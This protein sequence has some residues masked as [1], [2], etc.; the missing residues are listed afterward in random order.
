FEPL[1]FAWAEKNVVKVGQTA[2]IY[3]MLNA[4][5]NCH[6]QAY[7]YK[8]DGKTT[9]VYERFNVAPGEV[10][11]FTDSPK[12]EGG[13]TY[14]IE[15]YDGVST[16]KAS[17][18]IAVKAEEPPPPGK[19]KKYYN[20]T[21]IVENSTGLPIKGAEVY[22]NDAY[23]G[24]TLENGTLSVKNIEEGTYSLRVTA[25][26]YKEYSKV[27]TI[28]SNLV[29]VTLEV[30][31]PNVEVKV[32]PSE[33]WIMAGEPF[34]IK[35]QIQT[36]GPPILIETLEYYTTKGVNIINRS[37]IENQVLQNGDVI[38]VYEGS[39]EI[40]GS[41]EITFTLRYQLINGERRE[42]SKTVNVHCTGFSASYKRYIELEI[43]VP[44]GNGTLRVYYPEVDMNVVNSMSKYLRSESQNLLN[45]MFNGYET[46]KD[47]VG[48]E[49]ETPY[50][51][52][53][54]HVNISANKVKIGN[55]F[56]SSETTVFRIILKL[57]EGYTLTRY[58][59][60]FS[61]Y[62]ENGYLTAIAEFSATTEGFT[63]IFDK[64]EKPTGVGKEGGLSRLLPLI[65]VLAAIIIGLM[66][67]LKS[68]PKYYRPSRRFR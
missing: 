53:Y 59:Q 46:I 16:S 45:S 44:D 58:P 10:A 55:V 62:R 25:N 50:Y 48:L 15:A 7:V 36:S 52:L 20:V 17:L 1:I 42:I 19:E 65:G 18:Q 61:I 32:N 22:L 49:G 11:T 5:F 21:F 14:V 39:A 47:Y 26:G 37:I 66:I 38:A 68:R 34:D 23:I 3:Y 64:E 40:E 31:E 12:M 13:Y 4:S 24:A 43:S 29:A 57:E 28:S 51:A 67:Y 30:E 56:V 9:K 63:I 60:Y 35:I 33:I 27:I 54:F 6:I 8:P 2:K 41:F